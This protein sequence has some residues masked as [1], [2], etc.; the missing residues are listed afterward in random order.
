MAEER[1]GHSQNF[2]IWSIFAA[3]FL[4]VL[5][6]VHEIMYIKEQGEHKKAKVRFILVKSAYN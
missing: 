2:L 4:V 1:R 3:F 5:L 6:Q